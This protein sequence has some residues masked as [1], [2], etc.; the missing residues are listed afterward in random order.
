MAQNREHDFQDG[1]KSRARFQ[2]AMDIYATRGGRRA[3]M[4]YPQRLCAAMDTN[5][6]LRRSIPSGCAVSF[7]IAHPAVS[8][9]IARGRTVPGSGHVVS[10]GI[11]RPAVSF[12]IASGTSGPS[13]GRAVSFGIARPAEDGR[14]FPAS[15]ASGPEGENII[16]DEIESTIFKMA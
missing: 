14:D 3:P 5:G 13:S 1:P 6:G 4:S 7:G 12:G 2:D 8:F 9:G 16:Q 10:F 11:T 15:F